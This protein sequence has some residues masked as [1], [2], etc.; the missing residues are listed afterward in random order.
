MYMIFEIDDR[1]Q[2]Q[3]VPPL[4]EKPEIVSDV[5]ILKYIFIQW[6]RK[7]EYF[8]RFS[9]MDVTKNLN[10]AIFSEMMICESIMDKFI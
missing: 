5:E 10:P 9:F 2:H 4:S 1:C 6:V 7:L 3:K 8:K